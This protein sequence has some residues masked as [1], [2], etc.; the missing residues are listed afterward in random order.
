MK[1]T[2]AV[3]TSLLL[4]LGACG[5]SEKG[6]AMSNQDLGTGINTVDRRY[7]KPAA[8]VWDAA[9]AATKSFDLKIDDD[10]HDKMGGEIV[11]RR[12]SGER[13]NVKVRS[14]DAQNTDVSVRIEPGNK[15]MATMMQEKIAEKVGMGQSKAGVFGDKALDGTYKHNLTECATAAEAACR[16]LNLDVTRKDVQEKSVVVDARETNSN[17]VRI[18]MDKSDERTTKVTFSAGA[19]K[20]SDPKVLTDRL[21]AEFERQIV[22][23]NN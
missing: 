3:L 19:A 17:P 18:Q 16:K 2:T 5:G 20:G 1:A 6:G 14:I 12:A 22:S 13:V 9:I 8:E 7:A 23:M 21:K 4:A 15:N 11:A 10:R